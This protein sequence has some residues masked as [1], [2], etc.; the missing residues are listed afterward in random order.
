MKLR[1]DVKEAI[2]NIPY[3]G[4]TLTVK[5]LENNIGS[6]SAD[7]LKKIN[8]AYQS[9]IHDNN[10]PSMLC[11]SGPWQF[12]DSILYPRYN[13]CYCRY[14]DW[15]YEDYRR[16]VNYHLNKMKIATLYTGDSTLKREHCKEVASIL[17][18]KDDNRNIRD[19]VP[20]I[21]TIQLPHHGS[22]F[23]ITL[24]SVE[25]YMGLDVEDLITFASF[26]LGNI[27]NH[28]NSGLI[29]DLNN[30]GSRFFEVNEMPYT[31]LEDCLYIR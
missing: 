18:M 13:I 30:K 9:V 22:K 25:K 11:Y 17:K 10:K 1:D 4:R 29:E 21:G 7:D 28:P 26:G 14:C 31:L 24:N 12:D 23:N 6:L 20:F 5:D 15:C 3:K 2:E 27:Y 16:I 19:L 8:E